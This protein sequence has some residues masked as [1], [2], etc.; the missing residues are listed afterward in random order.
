MVLDSKLLM[1]CDTANQDI[2]AFFFPVFLGENV[3]EVLRSNTEQMGVHFDLRMMPKRLFNRWKMS[4]DWHSNAC[5]VTRLSFGI[6]KHQEK[7]LT[8]WLSI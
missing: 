4:K 6:Q 8:F 7:A 2:L 5:V 3:H 1:F